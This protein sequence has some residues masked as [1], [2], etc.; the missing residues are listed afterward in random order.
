VR[1]PVP[2]DSERWRFQAEEHALEEHLGRPSLRMRAGIGTAT[3]AVPEDGTVEFDLALTPDRG[4]VGGIWRVR[5][6][7]NFEWFYARPH[8]SGNPDATQLHAGVQRPQRLA[9]LPRGALRRR[10]PASLRRVVPTAWTA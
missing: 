7:E 2:F 4:F 9:D 10:G 6:E 1:E 5:D 3:D 8:Q